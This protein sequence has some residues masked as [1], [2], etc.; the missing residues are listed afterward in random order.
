MEQR[1]VDC[2]VRTLKYDGRKSYEDV[3][4]EASIKLGT[5][6]SVE[7][8]EDIIKHLFQTKKIFGF[9]CVIDPR[10]FNLYPTVIWVSGEEDYNVVREQL[11][12]RAPN[13]G[14]ITEVLSLFG[15]Y[16]FQV[17]MYT[18]SISQ[19]NS[20]INNIISAVDSFSPITTI[21]TEM[22][23]DNGFDV[24]APVNPIFDYKT[25]DIDEKILELLQQDCRLS[26]QTIAESIDLD[27]E[28]VTERIRKMERGSIIQGYCLQLNQ[29]ELNIV[30]AIANIII[31]NRNRYPYVIE[32]VMKLAKENVAEVYSA[33]GGEGV[34]TI[35]CFHNSIK[36]LSRLIDNVNKIHGVRRTKSHVIAEFVYKDIKI[37][38]DYK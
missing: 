32:H 4:R 8:V 37:P 5:D 20:D 21:Q 17:R 38:L 35:R 12:D 19:A 22:Y 11:V 28:K 3:S 18:N 6:I 16:D 29:I 34:I 36:E 1:V 30:G 10:A 7:T 23:R 27:S 26:D 13:W 2:I 14:N 31:K 15:E 9:S 25:D 33:L 24:K